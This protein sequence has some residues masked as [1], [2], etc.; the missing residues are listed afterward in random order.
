MTVNNDNDFAILNQGFA[1]WNNWKKG[2]PNKLPNLSNIILSETQPAFR[3]LKKEYI[4]KVF[5]SYNFSGTNFSNSIIRGATFNNCDL[6][7]CNFY[8]SD[9]RKASFKDCNLT[10]CKFHITNLTL[11]SFINCNFQESLFW[12]TILARTSFIDNKNLNLIKHGG[13]SIIDHR[14]F[15]KSNKLPIELLRGIGLTEELIKFYNLNFTNT[16]LASCFISH[17]SKDEEFVLKLYNR[18]QN[19]GIRCWYAPKDLNIGDKIRDEIE[20]AISEYE[21]I[22]II[23]SKDSVDSYWVEDEV[24]TAIEKEKISKKG[25]LI[26]ISLDRLIFDLDKSWLNKIKRTRQIG[27][28]TDWKNEEKFKN[29]FE[30]LI[31]ALT[32]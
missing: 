25:K 27:D 14:T 12:E 6:T 1:S 26:P 15:Q 32:K 18:L 17:S 11:A 24:E 23:L 28:F 13:P 19:K 3:S 8:K 9:L 2:N 5:S 21:K 16:N 4:P 20:S 22:L 10:N 29:S 30:S 7:N 31:T